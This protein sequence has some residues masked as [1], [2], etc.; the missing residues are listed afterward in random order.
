M[1]AQ[2]LDDLKNGE[3]ALGGGVVDPLPEDAPF[4]VADYYDYYKKGRGYHER[5]LKFNHSGVFLIKFMFRNCLWY[6]L[7]YGKE[8]PFAI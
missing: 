4:F 1:C 3:Y 7:G 6:S 2:R 5:S 8:R